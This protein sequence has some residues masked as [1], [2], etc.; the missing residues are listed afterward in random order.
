MRGTA[1]LG[2]E[3]SWDA[4]VVGDWSYVYLSLPAAT[5]SLGAGGAGPCGG[6]NRGEPG[7]RPVRV[8]AS[9]S[10]LPQGGHPPQA[11]GGGD[12]SP[13]RE[14]VYDFDRRTYVPYLNVKATISELTKSREFS[15]SLDPMI[16]EWIHYGANITLPH[17][18]TYLIL[19]DIQS[20]DIARYKHMADVWNTP[21]QA[22]FT[23]EYH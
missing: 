17:R 1:T 13:G 3:T 6:E 12:P 14:G 16:G 8:G 23:Y 11:Q 15:V 2:E 10:H 18:G 19:I 5:G 21:A 9:A 7:D 4:V 22:V 20:P